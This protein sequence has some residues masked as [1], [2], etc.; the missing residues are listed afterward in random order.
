MPQLIGLKLKLVELHL[1]PIPLQRDLISPCL[2]LKELTFKVILLEQKVVNLLLIVYFEL[3][4]RF[5]DHVFF[6]LG[7]VV[8]LL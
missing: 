7:D 2:R 1:Q 3:V 4:K 6:S 5:F 8:F